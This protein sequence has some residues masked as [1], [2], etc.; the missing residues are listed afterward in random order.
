MEA[1]VQQLT[2]LTQEVEAI[3]TRL[4]EEEPVYGSGEWWKKEMEEAEKEFKKGKGTIIND[5]KELARFF[6]NL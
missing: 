3:K 6:K 5:K 4:F 1:I 2:K